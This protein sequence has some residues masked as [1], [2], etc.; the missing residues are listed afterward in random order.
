MAPR[1][2]SIHL[3]PVKSLRGVDV[4]ECMV[5]RW[6]LEHDR[7]WLLLDADGWAVTARE[8]RATLTVTACPTSGGGVL[9]TGRDGSELPVEAPVAGELAPTFLSRLS[10]VRLAGPV[11]DAWLSDQLAQSVRLGWLDD[12][13]RRTVSPHHGGRDGDLLNLA[14]AGPL[15]VTSTTSLK[16]VNSWIAE[17]APDGTAAEVGM[18][19]F[20]PNVVID[21]LGEAFEEDRWTRC[22]V[23]GVSFRLAEHCDRCLITLVDPDTFVQGKEPLRTLARHHRWDGKAWFG[24]RMIPE[25]TGPIHVGDPL[26]AS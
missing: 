17:S 16:Q 19:R 24:V 12:P 8:N 11:A 20:R 7:R 9:L 26:T 2:S 25:N 4:R 3:Y 6:G 23:G 10:R 22:V 18:K 14:D 13:R 21:G 5:E 15:L 1:V